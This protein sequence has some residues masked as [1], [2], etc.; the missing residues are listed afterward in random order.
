MGLEC[1][2]IA[3]H[4]VNLEFGRA[5]GNKSRFVV[6][7]ADSKRYLFAFELL[8][9]SLEG[10]HTLCFSCGQARNIKYGIRELVGA[11]K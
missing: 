6:Q 3:R 10:S 4:V 8:S 9:L 11:C 2:V 1:R 7:S 5:F